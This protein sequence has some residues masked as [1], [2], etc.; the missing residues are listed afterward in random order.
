MNNVDIQECVNDDQKE[1]LTDE[2]IVGL[3]SHGD[4]GHLQD[5]NQGAGNNDRMSC[6]EGLKAIQTA[7]AQN[8]QQREMTVTTDLLL[9]RLWHNIAGEEVKNARKLIFI[10]YFFKK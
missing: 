6:G 4:H 1:Q 5:D 3:V 10:T 7:P 9:C 2:N 8:E